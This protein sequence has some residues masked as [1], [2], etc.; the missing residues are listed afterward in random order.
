MRTSHFSRSLAPAPRALPAIAAAALFVFAFSAL[1]FPAPAATP[2]SA[3]VF[4]QDHSDLR[5]DPAVRF[6]TLKNGMRYAILPNAE[7]KNRASLRLVVAS[8]ALQENDDQR[9]LAHFLEHLAFGG[10]EHY[11]PGT[12]VEFFQRM[13]MNF[14]GDTNAFTSLDR[15]QY[16]LELPDTKPATLAEGLTVFADYAGGLLLLQQTV[17]KERGIILSEKRARDSVAYREYIAENEFLLG[18]TR[19]PRR[20]PIGEAPVIEQARRDRFLDFYNTWYRPER[21]AVIAVGDFDPA[22]LEKQIIEK[23]SP[24]TDRGPARPDPD[25]GA[26]DRFT[27]LRALHHFEAESPATT[28]GIQTMT[29]KPGEPDTAAQRLADLPRDIAFAMLNRRLDILAKK[30]NSSFSDAS[31]G[32]G[33]G[34]NFFRNTSLSLTCK[35]AQW[36]AALAT[37]ERELRRAL[38]HGFTAAELREAVSTTR[39]ALEQAVKTAPTRR[40]AALANALASALMDDRVF[41]TPAD[42]LALLAPA[43]DKLTPEACLAAFREAWSAPGRYLTVIGNAKIDNAGDAPSATASASQTIINTYTASAA[44][45]V[46][47][48]EKTDDTPFAYTDYGPPGAIAQR[49][50]IDDLDI[51][52]IT[53]ANG[54]RLNLK[55]TDFEAGKIRITLRIGSGQLTEPPAKP[56]LATLAGATLT[57][58][59]LGK[60]SADDLER[61]LAGRTVR[62]NFDA[63][64]DALVFTAATN[65]DDLLLQLQLL[66]A[67]I[68]DP[69]YRPEAMR[70]A[71]KYFEQVNLYFAH[72]A[73]GP[74]N[75][76]IPRLLANGDPRFGFPKQTELA[77]RTLDEV[78]AWLAP[79]F[80]TG[81]IEIAIIG[82]LDPDTAIAATAA[83]LGALPTRAAKPPLDAER[84]VTT[85]PPQTL[86]YDIASEI[87]KGVLSIYWPTTDARDVRLARRLNM[88]ANVFNDRLRVQI[89]EKLGDS[90]SPNA[91]S[92]SSD[93]YHDFGFITAQSII[94]PDKSAFLDKTITAIAGDLAT[95]GVTNDELARAKLPILTSLRESER[96]NAY[97]LNA[98]LASAQEQP[99]RLDWARTRYTDNES[100]TK[101]D[102]DALAKKYLP[103]ARAIRATIVPARKEK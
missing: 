67:Y 48:P 102:L 63:G 80:A 53:F 17:D 43:L 24:I 100:I 85:A 57:A 71:E 39:N 78:R 45:P 31:A 69:G 46:A 23:L 68:T 95:N 73:Q 49:R 86:H 35:A 51:D 81:P 14:G 30:E 52:L 36:P 74:L 20:M 90:Y 77:A 7:P 96:T 38:E 25:L 70:Q 12:L 79:Q 59:G 84:R 103:P 28:V 10:S 11:A 83:T 40:S 91:G 101:P 64:D 47:P 50:H 76:D 62:T 26:I 72:T 98:V 2:P 32:V 87:P 27:G 56:G 37:A 66:A 58:G 60:H 13:G 21:M 61:I 19:I 29:P 65:R 94:D 5:A 8:G 55:Q 99:Q 34:F 88:L 18:N 93:T 82:D 6:G 33:D 75:R 42:N 3:P 1:P 9:G 89:R 54:A 41:T 22:A 16:M 97:W 44:T 4:A 15:T 92:D